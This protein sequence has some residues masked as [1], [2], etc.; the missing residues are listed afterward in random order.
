MDG[1]YQV[2]YLPALPLIIICH[3]L[4][5]FNENAGALARPPATCPPCHYSKQK[6]LLTVIFLVCSSNSSAVRA[7]TDGHTDTHTHTDGTDFIPST[8]DAGGNN[9]QMINYGKEVSFGKNKVEC[10]F[11]EDKLVIYSL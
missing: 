2:H 9:Y 5:M 3:V 10:L 8:A 4:Y 7:L 11:H 1:R 6:V